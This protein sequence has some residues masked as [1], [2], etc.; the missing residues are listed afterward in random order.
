MHRVL[1]FSIREQHMQTKDSPV[2][3]ARFFNVPLVSSCKTHIIPFVRV[4]KHVKLRGNP[5][6]GAKAAL[7][8]THSTRQAI[9]VE[10]IL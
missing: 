10:V 9:K 8:F 1:L 3:E 4:F 7:P 5:H 6:L 2:I